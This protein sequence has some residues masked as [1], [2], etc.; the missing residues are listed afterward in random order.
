MT[1]SLTTGGKEALE[2]G[3]DKIFEEATGKQKEKILSVME[4]FDWTKEGA[5]EEFIARLK[6]I[7][8]EL[9]T[10]GES[11]EGFFSSLKKVNA[12]YRDF[13][14]S[15]ILNKAKAGFEEAEKVSG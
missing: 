8:P 12:I 10:A 15:D 13:N 3:F 4:T 1:L 6:E 7:A 9:V 14:L 5:G 2:E 11:V